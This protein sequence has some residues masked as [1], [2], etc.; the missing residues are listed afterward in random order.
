MCI[1]APQP[2]RAVFQDSLISK[3][4]IP[5]YSILS[6]RLIPFDLQ[7]SNRIGYLVVDAAVERIAH[8]KML[9]AN[10]GNAQLKIRSLDILLILCHVT[11]ED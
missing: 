5:N 3:I 7:S 2:W 9:G 8:N 4:Y 1:S 10:N 11:N 6:A